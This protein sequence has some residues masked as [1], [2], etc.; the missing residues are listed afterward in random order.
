MVG[1]KIR[2]VE[3]GERNRWSGVASIDYVSSLGDRGAK[4]R[5]EQNIDLER[6]G[7]E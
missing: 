7:S 1:G 5:E 6:G 4:K 2:R 3:A